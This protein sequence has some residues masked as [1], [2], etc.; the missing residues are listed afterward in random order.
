MPKKKLVI[1]IMSSLLAITG[2]SFFVTDR[3]A[4]DLE[5]RKLKQFPEFD[6][7]SSLDGSFFD[8]LE[9]Y[10]LDRLVV[11]DEILQTSSKI[12][13]YMMKSIRKNHYISSSGYILEFE[14]YRNSDYESMV[15]AIDV[16]LTN[17][18]KLKRTVDNESGQLYFIDIPQ[19]HDFHQ[20]IFPDFFSVNASNTLSYNKMLRTEAQ[21]NGITVISGIDVFSENDL[22][23]PYYKTDNHYNAEA[24][25]SI[26]DTMLSKMQDIHPIHR[27]RNTYEKIEYISPFIGNN[28]RTM[29]DTSYSKGEVFYYMK[30]KNT[31]PS[32]K[33]YENGKLSDLPIMRPDENI[34]L[35]GNFMDG[36]KENTIIDTDRPDLP[37]IL[38]IGD[39][40]TNALEYLAIYDFN[41][42]HSLDLRSYKDDIHHYI[43]N[44]D[45]DVVVFV[46]NTQ[47]NLLDH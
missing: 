10:M 20:E 28:A 35:Y 18:N 7:R 26:Y 30:P 5:Y 17:L 29:A 23:E 13:K 6:L 3:D 4:S 47:L 34:S 27:D 31:L 14:D 22:S 11:R 12:D 45:I 25:L 2:I 41:Q 9:T 33:R 24:A 44:Q 32:Y 36:D 43:Q 37:N 16:P 21:N 39:S 40:F 1:A 15:T 8:T 19:K 38:F 42:V 46:R